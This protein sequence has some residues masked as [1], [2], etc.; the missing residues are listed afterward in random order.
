MAAFSRASIVALNSE[1]NVIPYTEAEVEIVE[2]VYTEDNLVL[3][4][5]ESAS[6]SVDS[7]ETRTVQEL[8]EVVLEKQCPSD[9]EV[10]EVDDNPTSST[11]ADVVS[12]PGTSSHDKQNELGKG[13][14]QF[15][16]SKQGS[17]DF[18]TPPE[19]DM[20]RANKSTVSSSQK[21]KT[22]T[23][24]AQRSRSLLAE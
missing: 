21:N 17:R 5:D 1:A 13:R 20:S 9:N 7:T 23:L 24:N 10:V 11:L 14:S 6:T 2:E 19:R 18:M 12:K 8:A 22:A 3:S 15:R 16:N 4:A